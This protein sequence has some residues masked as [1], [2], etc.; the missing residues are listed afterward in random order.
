MSP[1]SLSINCGR[2]G[3]QGGTRNSL[4][5]AGWN[6]ATAGRAVPLPEDWEVV[7]QSPYEITHEPGTLIRSFQR[8]GNLRA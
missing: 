7:G 3:A 1:A 2:G 8:R 6:R 5:V 4:V